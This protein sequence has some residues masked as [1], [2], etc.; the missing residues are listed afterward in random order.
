ML[1][2]GEILEHIIKHIVCEHIRNKEM[3]TRSIHH[4]LKASHAK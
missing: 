4:F 2:P 3:I 1:T